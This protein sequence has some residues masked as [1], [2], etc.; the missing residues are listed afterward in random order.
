MQKPSLSYV[1][2]GSDLLVRLTLKQRINKIFGV[3][4]SLLPYRKGTPFATMPKVEVKTGIGG[5]RVK[6]QVRNVA[7]KGV[8]FSSRG[9]ELEFRI[10]RAI[11]GNPDYILSSAKTALKDLNV[12]EMAWRVLLLEA[13][14]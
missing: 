3:S 14:S 9:K 8:Q 13:V 7:L 1:C 5:L 12:D 2:E 6:D 11:L 10:P 4:L